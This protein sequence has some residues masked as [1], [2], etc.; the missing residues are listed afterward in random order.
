MKGEGG[1]SG[2]VDAEVMDEEREDD[3]KGPKGGAASKQFSQRFPRHF[4]RPSSFP[5]LDLFPSNRFLK[6]G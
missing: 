4:Q 6:L 2:L 1:V 5:L 3:K